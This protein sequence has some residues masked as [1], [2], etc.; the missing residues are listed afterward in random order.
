MQLYQDLATTPISYFIGHSGMIKSVAI[1]PDG[2]KL[3][4]G[5]FDKTAKDL[6]YV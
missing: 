3:V 2:S 6:E 5:S 1:S 4:T